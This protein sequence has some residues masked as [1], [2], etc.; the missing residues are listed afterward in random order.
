MTPR[1]STAT[2]LSRVHMHQG[3]ALLKIAQTYGSL[4]GMILEVVQNAIDSGAKDIWL[5]IDNKK[6][7]ITVQDN[8]S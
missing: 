7:S 2:K 6:R 1:A 5:R 4:L 3:Q 8:G